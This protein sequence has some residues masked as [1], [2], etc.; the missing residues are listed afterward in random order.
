[1]KNLGIMVCALLVGLSISAQE[2]KRATLT[3]TIDNVSGDEGT[4]LAALHTQDTFMKGAG[5]INRAQPAKKGEVTFIFADIEPGTYAISVM[6]DANDNKQ[7]D[8]EP[9]GM[10]TESYGM[11][12]TMNPYGPPVFDE[13]KFE[14][15]GEDQEF[16]IQF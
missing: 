5:I 13:V 4:V 10:P 8:R 11:T 7:M 9:N 16:R 6:H 14:A 3:V 2:K 12:G 15:N 1:M